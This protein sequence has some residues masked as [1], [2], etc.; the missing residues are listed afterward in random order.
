MNENNVISCPR[1]LF[2][3]Q[4]YPNLIVTENGCSVCLDFDKRQ[5][6]H[7]SR[8][9]DK[10]EGLDNLLEK[11]NNPK[12]KYNCVIGLSGGVDSSYLA[13]IIKEK[14]LKPVAVHLDNGWNSVEAV[15]NIQKIVSSLGIDLITIVINWEE[16]RELQ[17]A[18]FKASVVDIEVLTDHAIITSLYRIANK[19]NLRYVIS[20][21]NF[22]TENILP[23]DWFFP[24]GDH[25]NIKDIVSKNSNVKFKTYPILNWLERTYYRKVKKIEFIPILDYMDY[26]KEFALNLLENKIGYKKYPQK[27]FESVFTRFYQGYILRKKFNIDKRIAHL[28]SLVV[29]NQMTREDAMN[30]LQN[31]EY[32]EK[33]QKV[34]M[35]Y[36]I[37]KLNFSTEEFNS[38]IDSPVV[39]HYSYKTEMP[40]WR[41]FRS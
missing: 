31:N 20:G 30:V 28:S 11:I 5:Q 33:Q 12:G 6:Q 15:T 1:C 16:F 21:S 26:N 17:R 19:Y 27:H 3:T 13:Y 35:Q 34:D 9:G 25:V 8:I 2:T 10:Q 37:K 29:T 14:G 22:S 39:S 32:T 18:Y 41:Y 4:N 38:Y 7:N 23:T 36:V 40:F 24:K